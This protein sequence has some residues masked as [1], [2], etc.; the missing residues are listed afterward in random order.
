MSAAK[1][2]PAYGKQL[3]AQRIAGSM[4]NNCVVVAFEWAV[5]G[6]FPRVVVPD[7]VPSE[8]LELRYLAGLDVT[9][10]YR[11]RDASRV[12]ELIA[13]IEAVNPRSLHTHSLDR[14]ENT[15]VKTLDEVVL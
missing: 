6:F 1:R 9:V 2:Y 5:G 14:H 3:M 7:G 12:P 4:P 15:F 8:R 11:D 10:P 13:A